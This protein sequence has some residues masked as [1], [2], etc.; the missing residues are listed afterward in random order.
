[1]KKATGYRGCTC[2]KKDCFYMRNLSNKC[3][4][5]CAY[6]YLTGFP[7]GE[8]VEE[9]TKYIK[10]TP[11]EREIIMKQERVNWKDYGIDYTS[12]HSKP[13]DEV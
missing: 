6:C 11:R 8:P 4:K 12:R 10:I 7:R 2:V 13:F 5:F 3:D 9:C 1:M